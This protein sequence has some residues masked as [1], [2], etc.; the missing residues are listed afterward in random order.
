MTEWNIQILI[1]S[2]PCC[3]PRSGEKTVESLLQNCRCTILLKFEFWERMEGWGE[4]SFIQVRILGEIREARRGQPKYDCDRLPLI[5]SKVNIFK[6]VL[7]DGKKERG[8]SSVHTL[9]FYIWINRLHAW[10]TNI[11]DPSIKI[12]LPFI[13]LYCI[14][15]KTLQVALILPQKAM[16][17]SKNFNF[18]IRGDTLCVCIWLSYLHLL[19]CLLTIVS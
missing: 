13:C 6:F 14:D 12:L 11:S 4:K 8:D 9:L 17:P 5:P 15:Q 19:S 18:Q 3:Q 1:P 7:G 10:T 16:Y 2:I